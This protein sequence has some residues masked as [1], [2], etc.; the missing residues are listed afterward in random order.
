MAGI[1]FVNDIDM[2][3]NEV[4]N[5]RVPRLNGL[6]TAT[7]DMDGWIVFN[8]QDSRYYVAAASAW[9]GIPKNVSSTLEGVTA[10]QL[11]D[12]TTHTGQQQASTISD[13]HAA[14]I[15][16]KLNEFA[17]PDGT[18]NLGGQKITA[19]AN[20]TAASDAVNKA[21]LDAVDA[22]ASA[23]AS[24][25]AIK[26]AARAVAKT[27]ITLSGA[28]TIDGVAIVAGDR[29]LVTGQADA[30]TNGIYVAAAAAW[31]R[32]TD[33]DG[34]GELGSGT[35][36]GI[37]EGTTEADSLWGLTTDNA[38][39][40]IVIGTDNQVWTRALGGSSGEIIIAGNG[41]SK[42]GTTLAVVAKPGGKIVVDGSGVA[43]DVGASGV[44]VRAEGVVPAGST[45]ATI[46]H[47]LGLRW[48]QIEFYE[49]AS[50]IRVFPTWTP[51]G[52]NGG[53]AEFKTAPTANLYTWSART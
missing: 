38:T 15:V 3:G 51:T 22:K 41:L 21:Q 27:A 5:A 2:R 26:V 52:V 39:G 34:A 40:V 47:N 8:T 43:V 16:S 11:R 45:S 33:A 35:L 28:Q 24:G 37:R 12:R 18:L 1:P 9:F 48:V 36:I 17:A 46:T 20:G 14:V 13:F 32:S 30:K 10:A 31:A 7:A 53:V 50:G 29:V 6:P 23:A 4:Q 25:I 42:T 19:L 49:T 44:A